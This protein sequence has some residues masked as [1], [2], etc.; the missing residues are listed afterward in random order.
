MR[1]LVLPG[2][3]LLASLATPG[4]GDATPCRACPAIEGAYVVSW[5]NG[6][7]MGGCPATGPQP[8]TL[9][10]TRLASTVRVTVGGE[11]LAGTLY[12]TYDFTLQGGHDTSYSMRGRVILL[13]PSTDGGVRVTGSLTT[14][15]TTDAGACELEEKFTGDKL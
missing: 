10:F 13:S 8:A 15:A 5:Q 12:D 4:C 9:N 3:L 6:T 11:E 1:R 7:P 14:R 2:A